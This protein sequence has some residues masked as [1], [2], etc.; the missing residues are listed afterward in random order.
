M[1]SHTDFLVRKGSMYL[2]YNSNLL[3]HGCIPMNEDGSFASVKYLVMSY[4]VKRQWTHMTTGYRKA[5]ITELNK[6]NETD[7]FWYLWCGKNSPL[8]ENRNEN[9]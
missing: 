8:S 1:T 6:N 5:S 9:F 7:V 4:Q 3:I 2:K